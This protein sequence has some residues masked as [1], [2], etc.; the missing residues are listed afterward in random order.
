MDTDRYSYIIRQE[1]EVVTYIIVNS[2]NCLKRH[3]SP[4][5]SAVGKWMVKQNHYLRVH[6]S[7]RIAAAVFMVQSNF[8][9]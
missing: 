6:L 2:K 1:F 4:R 9:N 5:G 7:L 8:G 3:V